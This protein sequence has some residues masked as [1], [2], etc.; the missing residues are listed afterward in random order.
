M[1]KAAYIV[2]FI[3]YIILFI[4]PFSFR[5]FNIKWI[6]LFALIEGLI[7]L[8]TLII[9][10]YLLNNVYFKI[11][12]YLSFLMIFNFTE[13]VN[14]Q[15]FFGVELSFPWRV[16]LSTIAVM[17]IYLALIVEFKNKNY[18]ISEFCPI[19][20]IFMLTTLLLTFF[21]VIFYPF[22]YSCYQIDLNVNFV[23]FSN[24]VKY[25]IIIV[26]I[27]ICMKEK[28]FI[29][30]LNLSLFTVIGAAMIIYFLF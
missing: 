16:P 3:L 6:V 21:V 5:E 1:S 11:F 25:F 19:K 13:N 30:R 28:I 23:L 29:K 7:L 10:K 12:L 26:S 22:I 9:R 17:L 15:H 14:F 4:F 20:R 8:N 2:E 18:F 24:I 27:T